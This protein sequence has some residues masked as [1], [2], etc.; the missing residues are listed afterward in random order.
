MRSWGA[1]WPGHVHCRAAPHQ[2]DRRGALQSRADGCGLCRRC[3]EGGHRGGG[4]RCLCAGATTSRGSSPVCTP[5][6]G[7]CVRS[8]SMTRP[9]RQHGRGCVCPHPL[10]LHTLPFA[11]GRAGAASWLCS[12]LWPAAGW[13]PSPR[14]VGRS[15]GSAQDVSVPPLPVGFSGWFVGLCKPQWEPFARSGGC[16]RHPAVVFLLLQGCL[17]E[18]KSGL[19]HTFYAQRSSRPAEE[20]D[21]RARDLPS[22]LPR[23]GLP[24][25]PP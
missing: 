20:P 4:P 1:R 7:L 8:A 19:V 5:S 12:E 2:A 10:T 14:Q 3:A 21:P 9:S 25:P 15:D 23:E 18:T 16:G 6:G 11:C 24:L 22:R 13:R 17:F